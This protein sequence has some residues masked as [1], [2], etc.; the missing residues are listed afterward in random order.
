MRAT[1]YPGMPKKLQSKGLT[2]RLAIG[3]RNQPQRNKK[4]KGFENGMRE[5]IDPVD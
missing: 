1:G 2:L 4:N 5:N 3:L